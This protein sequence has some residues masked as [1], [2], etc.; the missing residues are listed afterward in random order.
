M[1]NKKSLTIG[2]TINLDNYENLRLELEGNIS[3]YDDA[4]ILVSDLDNILSRLGRGDEVTAERIDS[5]RRRVLSQTMSKVEEK[6]TAGIDY[7][8]EKGEYAGDKGM[9]PAKTPDKTIQTEEREGVPKG[10]SLFSY[11]EKDA[12]KPASIKESPPEAQK[13]PASEE[14]IQ[15]PELVCES[16]GTSITEKQRRISQM[17]TDKNLCEKCI[18]AEQG[19]KQ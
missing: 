10:G 9:N 13:E 2:I 4:M 16:C 18:Q 15:S 11:E 7:T 3:D 14:K 6:K 1:E 12:G 19:M 5:Y 17:F 8:M